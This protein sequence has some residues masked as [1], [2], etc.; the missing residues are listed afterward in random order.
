LRVVLRDVV[1]S[2]QPLVF[3]PW[4]PEMDGVY[5]IPVPDTDEE[6]WLE[7]V[8]APALGFDDECHRL[9]Y[10][11]GYHDRTLA[12]LQSVKLVVGVGFDLCRLDTIH[13]T[14]HDI[15]MDRIVTESGIYA[16][17]NDRSISEDPMP[18]YAAP[19]VRSEERRVG[20][21]SRSRT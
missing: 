1:A 21:E 18:L 3:R 12:R 10:G 16:P 15:P 8:A 9:G 13:P 4:Q 14:S 7:A 6:I 5:G 2:R 20:K 11:G 17:W 19:C